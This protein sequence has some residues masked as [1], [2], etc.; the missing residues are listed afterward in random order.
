MKTRISLLFIIF[1]LLATTTFAQFRFS[2]GAKIGGASTNLTGVGLKDFIPTPKVKLLGGVITNFAYGNRLA[3]QIEALYSGKGS[4]FKYYA[5]NSIYV[6]KA[7]VEEKLG[8][9]AVPIMLQFKMGDKSNYFH[10]DGGIVYN[11]LVHDKYTGT[12]I[13]VDDKGNEV[14]QDLTIEQD[15]AKSDLSYA[16]GIGLVANGLNFDFRYEIGTK[17][18]FQKVEGNPEII[19]RS[20]QVS[21]G[22]TLVY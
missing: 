21:V 19:N 3:L 20:F 15:P 17:A 22:Y 11:T 10:F 5:D 18:V 16:F 4:A 14:E 2:Y 8:Y 1:T 12:I 9:F 6:G 7:N 13:I